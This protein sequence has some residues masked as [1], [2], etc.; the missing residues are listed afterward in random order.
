MIDEDDNE[1]KYHIKELNGEYEYKPIRSAE[2]GDLVCKKY[3][4][5]E[6]FP[7]PICTINS[8]PSS[9]PTKKTKNKETKV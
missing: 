4:F 9:S 8:N 5:E 2:K 7:K 1:Y 3:L 6:M